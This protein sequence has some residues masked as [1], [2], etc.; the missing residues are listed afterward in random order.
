MRIE[1]P[2]LV[3]RS[4]EQ[5]DAR[6]LLAVFG[7][8]E[9]MRFGDGVK[10]IGWINA[11]IEE[12][13]ICVDGFVAWAVA[14]K[15]DDEVVGYC[16]LHCYPDINGRPEVELGYRLARSVWGRGLATEAAQAV[17]NHAVDELGLVRLVS[18]IDPGN[19]A[20]INVA[21]KLGLQFEKEIVLK[22]YTHPDHLYV[23]ASVSNA[24]VI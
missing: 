12:Q 10:D 7:D 1:T 11:W 20:S 23:T 14:E 21:R 18:L 9:V 3:I 8:E 4:F 15:P 17:M 13:R 19:T 16:G 5:D 2:R 6:A 22:G 24:S